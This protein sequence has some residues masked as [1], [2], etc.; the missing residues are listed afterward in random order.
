MITAHELCRYLVVNYLRHG[1]GQVGVHVQVLTE[2]GRCV[3]GAPVEVVP[4]PAGK[5]VRHD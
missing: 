1:L 3:T 2:D 4:V 5:A